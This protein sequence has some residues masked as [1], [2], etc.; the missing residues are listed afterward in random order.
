MDYGHPQNC[1]PDMLKTYV[2]QESLKMDIMGV[3]KAQATSIPPA[4]TGAV[5]WRREGL[6]YRKNEV[7]LDVVEHV[8]VLM[9]S[10][11]AC[12]PCLVS[13]C[14]CPKPRRG[15]PRLALMRVRRR[16]HGASER[17]CG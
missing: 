13:V 12:S 9:S 8:N 10:K 15:L 3:A 7:F 14:V 17:R 11:G 1:S 4:V 2:L 16:R 6:R 5:S